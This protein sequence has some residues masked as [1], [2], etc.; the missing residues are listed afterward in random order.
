MRR[1]L[2]RADRLARLTTALPLRSIARNDGWCDAPTDPNY[3]RLVTLPYDASH[4]EMW[5]QDRLYDIVVVLGFNDDPVIA[6]KGSAIFLHIAREGYAPTEGCVA[7][8]L[9]DLVDLVHDATPES[10][11]DIAK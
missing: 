2:Y 5:R 8:A 1:V 4:E 11:V 3:N 6:G 9:P 7:L 10:V